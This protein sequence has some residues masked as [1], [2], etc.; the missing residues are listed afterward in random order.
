M[1]ACPAQE[2]NIF[3]QVFQLSWVATDWLESIDLARG[4]LH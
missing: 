3:K 2:A 1:P 4:T